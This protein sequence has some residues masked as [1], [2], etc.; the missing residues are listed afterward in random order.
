MADKLYHEQYCKK[1]NQHYGSHLH[2]CPICVG[3]EMYN[4]MNI[5]AFDMTKNPPEKRIIKHAV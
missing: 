5:E 2:R 3:E 1:H 4:N